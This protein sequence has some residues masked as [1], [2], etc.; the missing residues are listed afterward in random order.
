[1]RQKE[2]FIPQQRLVGLIESYLQ[3]VPGIA[4][5]DG[6]YVLAAM[7]AQHGLLVERAKNIHSFS[8]LTLQEY[9]T[10]HYIVANEARGSLPR[11]MAHVGDD[12]W[13]EVFC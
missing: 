13:R 9:F 3:G 7:E 6:A 2:Y 8:H 5:P 4:E 11:L 10:A 1:L 12:R